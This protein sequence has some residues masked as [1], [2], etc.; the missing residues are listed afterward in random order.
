MQRGSLG[1]S[2]AT[3]RILLLLLAIN[4]MGVSV[5]YYYNTGTYRYVG[6]INGWPIYWYFPISASVLLSLIMFFLGT[7]IFMWSLKP[8]YRK[9]KVAVVITLAILILSLLVTR[10]FYV[11]SEPHKIMLELPGK[12]DGYFLQIEAAKSILH[13]LNPYKQDYKSSFLQNL[14]PQKY[15]WIYNNNTPPYTLGKVIGF[16]HNYDYMP[17]AALYYVP[18]VLFRIPGIVWDA[19]MLAFGLT[20]VYK[21]LRCYFKVLFPVLL[22]SSMFM[23]IASSI[24]YVPL[25]GWLVPL[26]LAV[27]FPDKP[28]FAGVLLAWSSTYRPYVAIFALFYLIAAYYEGYDVKRMF[29]SAIVVG[30]LLNVPFLILNP[31]KFME[32]ILIPLTSNLRPLDA[33]PGLNSLQYL[34]IYIPKTLHD[35]FVL[36]T[37]LL[38]FFISIKFYSKLSYT[39]FMFPTIALYLYYRPCYVYYLW[40]PF[41]ALIAYATGFMR[42]SVK[43]N[44]VRVKDYVSKLDIYT[45]SKLRP[46]SAYSIVLV[47]ASIMDMNSY[48]TLTHNSIFGHSLIPNLALCFTL[49]SLP[50]IPLVSRRKPMR[51]RSY[52]VFLILGFSLVFAALLVS[53]YFSNHLYYVVMGHNYKPDYIILTKFAAKSILRGKNPYLQDYSV[54]MNNSRD[55]GNLLSLIQYSSKPIILEKIQP[56]K[57]Y[58]PYYDP[59]GN[60]VI[61]GYPVKYVTFYDYPPFSALFYI[62]AILLNIPSGWWLS[63]VYSITLLVLFFKIKDSGKRLLMMITFLAGYFISVHEYAFIRTSIPYVILTI[64]SL[65][66]LNNP[67]IFGALLGLS[68]TTMPEATLLVLYMFVMT[69]SEF[70][71]RYTRNAIISATIVIIGVIVPFLYPNPVEAIRRMYFPVLATLPVSGVGIVSLI[72]RYIFNSYWPLPMLKLLPYLVVVAS[73]ILY[74]LYYKR[75]REIGLMLPILPI[76]FFNRSSID[77]MA[78][79]PLIAFVAWL[80]ITSEKEPV[81]PGILRDLRHL[82]GCIR[83]DFSKIAASLR[84]RRREG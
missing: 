79:Y 17:T 56:I 3:K 76:M 20:L 33:G 12:T 45:F 54:E 67:W 71:Y 18:A 29:S 51:I 84:V 23:Y 30:L 22:A 25:V 53:F 1:L 6:S 69:Y 72:E 75:L 36:G 57:I 16:V 60:I 34:G 14:E 2:N 4:L 40:F 39:I 41:V 78:F 7:F 81:R 43:E 9:V 15:T 50:I 74:G 64:L 62:P 44:Y 48:N 58:T 73:L 27:I 55:F 82:N 59:S 11:G 26:L 21:H 37:I 70:G 38:G 19:I 35:V 10:I 46:F 83:D 66:F 63:I 31:Q 32:R 77:Y 49:V 52:H 42:R 5:F 65:C 61:H 68:A 8:S 13:G 24:L 47:L 28:L 80:M